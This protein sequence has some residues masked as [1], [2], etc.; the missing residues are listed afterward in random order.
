ME[1]NA[2]NNGDLW[3]MSRMSYMPGVVKSRTLIREEI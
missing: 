1:G 2:T 3:E